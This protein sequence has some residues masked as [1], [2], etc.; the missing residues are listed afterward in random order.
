[1]GRL[2]C[3][4]RAAA[5]SRSRPPLERAKSVRPRSRSCQRRRFSHPSRFNRHVLNLSLGVLAELVGTSVLMPLLTDGRRA[6]CEA[7][8]CVA[9]GG[10]RA[11]GNSLAVWRCG[12]ASFRRRELASL[13]G[14]LPALLLG[15][16]RWRPTA[17]PL[18][19]FARFVL[20]GTVGLCTAGG[21]FVG[22]GM[23][24]WS[25]GEASCRA[26]V[27]DA[28]VGSAGSPPGTLPPT[29]R[30]RRT[31]KRV[32]ARERRTFTK[33]LT[34]RLAGDLSAVGFPQSARDASERDWALELCRRSGGVSP[35][36]RAS[37]AS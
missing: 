8:T 9:E 19:G 22:G 12:G 30:W 13:G 28:R 14:T 7:P 37:S 36:R 21:R 29:G 33:S 23:S 25:F 17:C 15:E 20:V 18:G 34:M 16:G 1:V 4:Q 3:R 11:P 24:F 32:P 6:G 26:V 27:F 35:R 10:L 2:R 5:W 31:V